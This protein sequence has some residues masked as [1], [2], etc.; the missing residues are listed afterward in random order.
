MDD[1]DPIPFEE[2]E[3]QT[4][5]HFTVERAR[6]HAF[7]DAHGGGIRLHDAIDRNV[8]ANVQRMKEVFAR[9][10]AQFGEP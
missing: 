4:F 2:F 3:A 9:L 6:A 7:V 1:D 8:E 5:A 10:R